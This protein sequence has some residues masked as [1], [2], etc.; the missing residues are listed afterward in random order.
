MPFSKPRRGH[1][2]FMMIFFAC[3]GVTTEV[4]FTGITDA[5]NNTPLCGS[6]VMALA[7]KSYVWMIFIY[8][9]IPLLGHYLHHHVEKYHVIL[10]L[11]FYVALVYAIEFTSGL[12]LQKITGR[13]PWQYTEGWHVMGLIRLDYFPAW[14]LFCWILERLYLFIN[15]RVVQ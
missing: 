15:K 10:R 4:I 1:T 7:G 3:L 5:I 14:L 6:P 13:C 12:L 11:L 8:A 9:A 2:F